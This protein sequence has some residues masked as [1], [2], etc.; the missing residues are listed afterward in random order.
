MD[1]LRAIGDDLLVPKIELG[2]VTL[3]LTEQ[4]EQSI[5]LGKRLGVFRQSRRV[6]GDYLRQG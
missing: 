3:A 2:R 6:V 1:Q 4:L 5:T